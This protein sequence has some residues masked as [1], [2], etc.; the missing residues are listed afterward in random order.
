LPIAS[1][2]QPEAGGPRK[3]LFGLASDGVY[4]AFP[5]TREAV[6][7]YTAIPPLPWQA[8]AVSFLLHFP[9]GHPHRTL[10]G[11]L[12]CEARTFL[13]CGLAAPAAA[14]TCLTSVFIKFSNLA[15]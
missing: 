11:I 9:W 15:L 5:V 10:S 13:S 2:D 7:S 1:S 12:P 3:L 6:V 14:I 8:M 4:T